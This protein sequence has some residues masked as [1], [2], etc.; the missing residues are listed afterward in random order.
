[1]GKRK[2]RTGGAFSAVT[3][4][5]STTMVLVLLGTVV[6]FVLVASGFSRQVRENFTVE[7]L[8]NDSISQRDLHTLQRALRAL[9]YARRV[10]YISKERGTREMMAD[11]DADPGEFLGAS[12]I[13]AEF[14]VY[15]RADYVCRDSLQKFMP[16]LQANQHVT[17]VVYPLE[18]MGTVHTA[19]QRGS[20][21]LLGVALLL[22]FVSFSLINNTLRMGI[23]ARRFTIHTMRLVG[24]KRSFI[25][26]PFM[27]RAFAIGFI[28][29]TIASAGLGAAMWK[30]A[31]VNAN[32]EFALLTPAIAIAVVGTVYAC[33]LL[34]TLL[35]AFFSVN[36][37]L[38]MS[39]DRIFLR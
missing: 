37:Y 32:T 14:E 29:A 17:E 12:P 9:P 21:I 5:I 18:L 11:L 22:A 8:L 35:C 31:E 19:T 15:L 7:V 10:N 3:S 2:K 23:Y 30:I 6:L 36:R 20:L 27:L 38:R 25:R 33:G 26:R 39:T 4:C 16:A 1:M 34:L 13:P 28:S 24:A